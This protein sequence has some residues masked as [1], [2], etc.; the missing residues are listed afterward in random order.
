MILLFFLTKQKDVFQKFLPMPN[1]SATKQLSQILYK[2]RKKGVK[3]LFLA[4]VM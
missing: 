2:Y 4:S 3:T 1:F